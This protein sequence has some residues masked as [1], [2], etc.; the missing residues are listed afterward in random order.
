MLNKLASVFL[1]IALICTTGAMSAF[2]QSASNTTTELSLEEDSPPPANP[3]E[4]QRNAKL[5]ADVATLLKDA[6]AG[7]VTPA[8]KSQI[9]PSKGNNLSK[10]AKIAIVVGIVLVVT[11]IIV[12]KSFEYDCK[13]RCVL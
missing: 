7:K 9:Q 5:K 6:R 4:A 8:A 11:A 1:V 2:G 10:T 12:Y 3:N 13:S